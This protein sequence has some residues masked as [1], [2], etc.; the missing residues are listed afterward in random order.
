MLRLWIY[1]E[2]FDYWRFEYTGSVIDNATTLVFRTS[3]NS[4]FV[5]SDIAVNILQ[6]YNPD[7]KNTS[8]RPYYKVWRAGFTGG[9]PASNLTYSASVGDR[10]YVG[11]FYGVAAV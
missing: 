4:L 7:E 8:S 9:L 2:K 1:Y 11:G 3:D 6:W 5:G 10:V